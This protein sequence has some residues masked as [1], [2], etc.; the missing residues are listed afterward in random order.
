VTKG[1]TMYHALTRQNA[2][3]KDKGSAGS[4]P[5]KTSE[6][7]GLRDAQTGAASDTRR[8]SLQRMRFVVGKLGKH[9][10]GSRGLEISLGSGFSKNGGARLLARAAILDYKKQPRATAAPI[11]VTGEGGKESVG[12]REKNDGEFSAVV[13]N[14][15]T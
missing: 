6:G 13:E 10:A 11:L 5:T 1:D 9:M 14:R 8:T 2:F 12:K 4:R 3:E 7:G 15:P